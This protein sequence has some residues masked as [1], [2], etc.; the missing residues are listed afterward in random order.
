M[1][2]F[3]LK[4]L[5]FAAIFM[6]YDKLFILVARR[7]A[8]AEADK[9]LEY[10]V[11]GEI[12]KDVI[13][14]G[15]SMGSRDII[16]RQIEDS[17]GLSVYNLCYPGS[18][19]E[20]HEF[21]INTL[22][23]YNQK[24]K[25]IFLIMDEDIELVYNPSLIYRKDRL[26]PLVQYRPVWRELAK[27]ENTSPFLSNFI[28]LQRL[29]KYNF[30]LREKRFTPLD[31]IMEDGSMPVSWK[32]EGRELEYVKGDTAYTTREELPEKVDALKRILRTCHSENI[33][34]VLVFPPI[35]YEHSKAF[36]NRIRQLC[37]NDDE[38][39]VFNTENPVYR[40]EDYFNDENHL[41]KEGAVIFTNEII[42][43]MNTRLRFD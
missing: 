26:Y 35:Y 9:R 13:I 2:K 14:A 3:A 36:E 31:T 43:Y 10:L 38:F 25:V 34:L 4:L 11:N 24:P 28:I 42:Q 6:V 27:R 7:S 8:E 19:V 5:L 15:S 23:E 18:T 1:R 39:L 37:T 12:N 30:D 20:F 17:T 22:L 16:A 29:S 33:K 21:V 40:N 41:M 32:P